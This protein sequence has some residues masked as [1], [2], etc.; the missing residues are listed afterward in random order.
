MKRNRNKE[1]YEMSKNSSL[2]HPRIST[3]AEMIALKGTRTTQ[4]KFA[5]CK[6]V[7]SARITR[8]IDHP[9]KAGPSWSAAS[10][11]WQKMH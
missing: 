1:S 4:T 3:T 6:K 8:V 7:I 2:I 11:R 9:E 10:R 5:V